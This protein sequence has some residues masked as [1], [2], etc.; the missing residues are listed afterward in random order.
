ME[1]RFLYIWIPQ[2]PARNHKSVLDAMDKLYAHSYANIHRGIH[3][4][5]E[6]ATALYENSRQK[7]AAFIHVGVSAQLIFTR[8]PLNRSILVAM[9]WEEV[10]E[11]R[12]SHPAD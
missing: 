12:R 11:K 2:L 4:L 1:R 8:I 5:A 3:E 10:F 7:I 9:A 6:E